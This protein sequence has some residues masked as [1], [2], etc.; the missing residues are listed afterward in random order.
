MLQVGLKKQKIIIKK[1]SSRKV[2]CDIFLIISG[3]WG[4]GVFV[5]FLSFGGIYIYIYIFFFP[6]SMPK[7][8]GSSQASDNAESTRELWVHV[9]LM[10]LLK[11]KKKNHAGLFCFNNCGLLLK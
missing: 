11:K 8:Y 2:A 6:L 3:A 4:H 7:A 5:C 9:M 1:K 10:A